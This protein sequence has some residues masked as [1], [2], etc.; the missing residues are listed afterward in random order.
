MELYKQVKI[1]SLPK[2]NIWLTI[3]HQMG[4]NTHSGSAEGR[5]YVIG[6]L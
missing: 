5:K 2:L 3:Y 6:H 4:Q 1:P